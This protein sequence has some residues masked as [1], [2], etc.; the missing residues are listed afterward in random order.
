LDYF[1]RAIE[2]DP[3]YALPYAGL[4]AA[5]FTQSG[6]IAPRQIVPQAE[7]EALKA[8]NKDNDLAAAHFAL[9]NIK[10]HYDWDWPEAEK[11]YKRAIE[12]DPSFASAHSWFAVYLWVMERFDQ[13]LA[14]SKR[15]QE[16]EPTALPIRLGVGRS[17]TMAGKYDDAL[18]DYQEVLKMFPS[19]L[20][21]HVEIGLIFERKQ[22]YKE[23]LNEYLKVWKGLVP[24]D[25]APLSTLG[26]LYGKMGRSQ[27]ALGALDSLL[28]L[29]RTRYVSAC[30]I[31]N[32]Q[33]GLN[34]KDAAFDS[35]NRCFDERSWEIIFL[36]LDPAFAELHG[37][38]RFQALI[39]KL[40]LM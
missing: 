4:A 11:E 15:A 37:D 30:E 27:E 24:D 34:Q 6:S 18:R 38:S 33:S 21:I 8:I 32:I 3:N 35:L 14:E 2:I 28:K 29:A 22:M 9:A 5:L 26:H 36:K 7:L 1:R 39:K 13:A 16:L 12:L 20:G 10:L 19:A 23:A 40:K 17:L 25:S 31:A